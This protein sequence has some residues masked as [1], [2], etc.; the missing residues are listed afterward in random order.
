MKRHLLVITVLSCGLL[1]G[2][3]TKA[4]PSSA[5]AVSTAALSGHISSAQQGVS[6]ARSALSPNDGKAAVVTQWLTQH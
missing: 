1:A 3:A 4:D 2:C 5:P 6:D